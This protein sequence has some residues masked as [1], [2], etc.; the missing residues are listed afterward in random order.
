MGCLS[1]WCK[2]EVQFARITG[3]RDR[4][5]LYKAYAF[6]KEC[7]AILQVKCCFEGVPQYPLFT[8]LASALYQC[9][10]SGS[11]CK[12]YGE[13]EFINEDISLK[14][15]EDEWNKLIMEKGS[16][17]KNMFK[18]TFFEL[19]VQE[20]FFSLLKD[21]RKTI[22]GRCA[23]SN[24][25]RIEPGALVLLN[26]TA[27]L[28][29]KDVRRYASFSEMLE[30][31]DLSQVLPGVKTVQ[32]G[33]KIY[34]KFYTEEKEMSNGVLAICVSKS[35]PQPYLHLA[36]ILLGLSYGGIQSLLGLAH[37]VGAVSD[38]LPPPRS[39]L[40]SSFTLPYRPNVNGSA[41][42]HG[43]RALA[44]H[45]ERSSNKY[46]GIISG[47]DSTKNSL[48]MN[49]INFLIASCCWSNVHIVPPHGAVFEVRVADGYGARWSKDGAKFIGFLEPY[50]EDGYSKGW[51]H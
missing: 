3:G 48:A 11:F 42:T 24:Y 26:R 47:S 43:A 49:V 23:G 31:E 36:S 17:L 39:T 29:V 14:Q 18:S 28:E 7:S 40:L 30:T 8:R 37:T 1:G 33:V 2:G 9:I 25:S 44:K 16:D 22:E 10:I 4:K 21:G 34:R 20:P 15:K 46:W 12:T 6:L 19:H 51:K 50:M 27:V 35:S 13:I 32:E 45:T 38:A 5:R 41:L